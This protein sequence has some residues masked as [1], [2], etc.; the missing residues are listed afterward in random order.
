MQATGNYLGA[1]AARRGTGGAAGNAGIAALHRLAFSAHKS[2]G[3]STARLP[4][5]DER[6]V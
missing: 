4:F 2:A 1:G 3:A 6:G 5:T